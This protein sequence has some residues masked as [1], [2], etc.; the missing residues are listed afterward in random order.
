MW[1]DFRA[2]AGRL[3]CRYRALERLDTVLVDDVLRH[4]HLHPEHQIGVLGNRA[5]RIVDARIVDVEELR[6]RKAREPDIGD[7]DEGVEP[8]ARLSD[9][10]AAERRD[11]VR[12]GVARRDAGRC[13][14]MRHKLVGRNPDRGA[15]RIDMAVQVD[16]AGSH[17]L[18]V[19]AEHAVGARRRNVCLDCLDHPEAD[20]DI[21]FAA[22]IL[23]RIEHVPALDHEI[24]LVVRSHRGEC[25][26][27]RKCKRSG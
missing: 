5:R 15:V 19:G 24:E 4:A 12:T 1:H 6:D 13:P 2:G 26:R 17:Q 21:A 18:A 16:Q 25:G 14:L 23:A 9:H 27:A 10:M 3:A 7:V 22:Q 20:S 8:R 11:I